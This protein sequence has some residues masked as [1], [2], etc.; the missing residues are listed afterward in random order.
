M[1][2][3]VRR[4]GIS[5]PYN[6]YQILSWLAFL[7]NLIVVSILYIPY[8][9]GVAFLAIYYI[10]FST[11]FGLNLF[12]LIHDP[13]D[14]LSLGK[15]NTQNQSVLAHC[16]ICTSS[17]SPYSKHCGQCNR[18]VDNFDHHCRWLNTCIGDSNYKYFIMLIISLFVHMIEFLLYSLV[19]GLSS[20]KSKDMLTTA[21]SFIFVSEASLVLIF[22]F[23]LICLHIYLKC[24][25]L[26][27]YEHIT[28]KRKKS[29][30]VIQESTNDNEKTITAV[31][32][33]F[34]TKI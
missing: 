20:L 25:G 23:N 11:V 19:V 13:S 32:C 29:K 33:P 4:R 17:V 8:T 12:L 9:T 31:A 7:I 21:I 34:E 26:T 14:P 28:K 6:L 5:P 3:K 18:C 2:Q 22:D 1:E 15:T 16:S 30:K 24:K 27:T 10:S